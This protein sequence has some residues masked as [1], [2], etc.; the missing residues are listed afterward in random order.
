MT[1]RLNKGAYERKWEEG[2]PVLIKYTQSNGNSKEFCGQVLYYGPY[3]D[4]NLAKS[5]RIGLSRVLYV[6]IPTNR[7]DKYYSKENV[8]VSEDN[9]LLVRNFKGEQVWYNLSN[10]KIDKAISKIS[11]SSKK[12]Y[13]EVLLSL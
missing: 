2:E 8:R 4:F 6:P 10:P 7:I 5:E 13:L 11:G 3:Y 1:C 9:F 12:K